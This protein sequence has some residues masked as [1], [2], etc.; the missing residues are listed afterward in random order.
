MND[1]PH[2]DADRFRKMAE[3][4]DH[5]VE[6]ST[7]GGAAVIC[8]PGGAGEPIEVLLLDSR[9]DAAQFWSTIQS[10]ISIILSELQDRQQVAGGFRR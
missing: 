8:P 7:F 10:R 3:R 2:T 6:F 4:I 9:G 5:N 1:I